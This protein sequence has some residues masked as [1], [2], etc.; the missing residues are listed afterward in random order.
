MNGVDPGVGGAHGGTGR[1]PGEVMNV[2][3]FAAELERF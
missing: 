2:T 3:T 1:A